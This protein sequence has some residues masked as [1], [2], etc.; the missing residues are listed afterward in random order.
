M[1]FRYLKGIPNLV[2]WYPRESGFDIIGYSDADYAR[3][4]IDRKKYNRKPVN[5]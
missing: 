5:F 1:I 2:I 3:C 4:T